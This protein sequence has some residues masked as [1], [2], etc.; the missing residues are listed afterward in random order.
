MAVTQYIG[1]RYVPLFADPVEWSSENTYEPLTIVINQGNSYTSKQAV[2]K[3]ID[4]ANEDFWT[5]TGNYNAQVELYRR[6]TAQA[7]QVAQDAGTAAGNAQQSADAA[8]QSAD[9]A[10]QSADNAQSAVDALAALLPQAAFSSTNTVKTYVDTMAGIGNVRK[11]GAV[12]NDGSVS[13]QDIVDEI[14]ELSNVINFDGGNWTIN[15]PV[16]IDTSKIRYII[17]GG[18]VISTTENVE[19]LFTV[20]Y[21]DAEKWCTLSDFVFN[22]AGNVG[23]VVKIDKGN[24]LKIDACGFYNYNDYAIYTAYLGLNCSGCWFFH[25]SFKPNATAIYCRTDNQIIGCKSFRNGTFVSCGS[26]SI[27]EGC[28]AWADTDATHPTTFLSAYGD[29]AVNGVIVRNCEL[30][31]MTYCAYNQGAIF[32]GCSFYWNPT[33]D[34]FTAEHAIYAWNRINSADIPPTCRFTNNVVKFSNSYN[35]HLYTAWYLDNRPAIGLGNYVSYGNTFA[36]DLKDIISEAN[37][38]FAPYIHLCIGIDGNLRTAKTISGSTIYTHFPLTNNLTV[39]GG[40][41]RFILD[42]DALGMKIAVSGANFRASRNF[43]STVA[44]TST[45]DCYYN[46]ADN[47]SYEKYIPMQIVNVTRVYANYIPNCDWVVTTDPSGTVVSPA[48]YGQSA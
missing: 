9:D 11:Y 38:P 18:S 37:Y 29:N 6:D 25:D 22:C 19:T 8:Q 15:E 2:P 44:P 3:G 34:R 14:S 16:T 21:S 41:E 45:Y 23:T 27:I 13:W 39:S 43:A 35:K 5:L 17:G 36:N 46:S 28:Y 20:T 31:C 33:D 26:N 24:I 1:S 42:S 12:E 47:T 4:I 48:V 40:Q 10:Q 7:L 32:D 30:D